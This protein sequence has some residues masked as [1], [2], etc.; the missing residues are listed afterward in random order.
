MRVITAW[1]P[2]HCVTTLPTFPLKVKNQRPVV[3]FLDSLLRPLPCLSQLP[4]PAMG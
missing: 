4:L 3:N 1:L 2:V